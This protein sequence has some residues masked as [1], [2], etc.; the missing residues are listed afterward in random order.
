MA[1][2]PPGFFCDHHPAVGHQM[3]NIVNRAGSD[4]R[5]SRRGQANP[6]NDAYRTRRGLGFITRRL[7]TDDSIEYSQRRYLPS[8]IGIGERNKTE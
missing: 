1:R 8:L 3:T 6:T 7:H 2:R 4:R 5:P